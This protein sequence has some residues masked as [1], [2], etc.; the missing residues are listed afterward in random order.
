MDGNGGMGLLLL[1]IMDHS[2]IPYS[3]AVRY[4]LHVHVCIHIYIYMCVY[5]Y[6]I[7]VY[8]ICENYI[9]MYIYYICVLYIYMYIYYICICYIYMYIIYIIYVYIIYVYIIYVYYLFHILVASKTLRKVPQAVDIGN[10]AGSTSS[11]LNPGGFTSGGVHKW[12]Y[13]GVPQNAW[14]TIDNPHQNI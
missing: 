9:Y 2:L 14:L 13:M 8:I 3:A 6:I 10:C 7:Y 12:I 11:T 1:V 4:T 5:V